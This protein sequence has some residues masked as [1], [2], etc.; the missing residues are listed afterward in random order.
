MAYLD[1]ASTEPLHPSA[2]E[3]LLAAIDAGWADPARLYR[4]AR[5][6]R[7][8]LDRVDDPDEPLYVL[9]DPSGHP[10]CLFVA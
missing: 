2:R 6:A 3:T 9:A 8:L 5:Q 1:A 4:E 7:L 10:F